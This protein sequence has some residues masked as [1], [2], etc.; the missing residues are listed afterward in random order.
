[1]THTSLNHLAAECLAAYHLADLL[2]DESL[3]ETADKLLLAI[4]DTGSDWI[5]PTWDLYYSIQ[6]DG[7]YDGTD[8]PSLTYN[9]LFNLQAYITEKTG[10]Q[11]QTIYNLMYHKLYWMWSN[12]VTDYKRCAFFPCALP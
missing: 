5:K 12:N 1:M 8:Y 10:E 7:T 4:E 6:P 9:D 3:R 11:N 2:Q